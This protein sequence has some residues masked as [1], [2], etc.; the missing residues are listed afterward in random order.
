MFAKVW[1][2]GADELMVAVTRVKPAST[3]EGN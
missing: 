1:I 3:A 2:L